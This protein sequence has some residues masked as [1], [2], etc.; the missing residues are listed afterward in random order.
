[1]MGFGN[2]YGLYAL[3]ALVPFII[4]YL[5]RPKPLERV[6]PSLM[7]L[8]KE[9]RHARQYSFLRKLL[10]NLLFL[11]QLLAIACI[12]FA[13]AIPYIDIP[14]S[15]ISD[16]TVVIIDISASMQTKDGAKT[17]FDNAI[18][19]VKKDLS[20]R[21]GIILAENNPLIILEN[22]R[23]DEASA[24]IDKLKPK[25][26]GTNLGD[27]M[28]LARSVLNGKGRVIVASDFISTEG[29]DVMT[30]K[31]TLEAGGN[32]VKFINVGNKADNIGIINLEVDKKETKA[33]IKNFKEK[34]ENVK[35]RLKKD[36]KML[37]EKTIE[38][39]PNSIESIVFSTP[40]EQ[41]RIELDVKDSLDAD[42]T[43]FISAPDKMKMSVLMITNQKSNNY[44]KSA[45]E[46]SGD[47][48]LEIREPP[49]TNAESISHDVV[50]VNKITKDKLLPHEFNYLEE[51]V[52]KGG[53]LIISAQDDLDKID[54]SDLL[55]AKLGKKGENSRVCVNL[56]I[57]FTKM[58]DKNSCFTTSRYFETKSDNRSVAIASAGEN[59]ILSIKE[60]GSGKVFYYGIF[61]ET[62]DFKTSI[63]YPL[64]WDALMG[65]LV[66]TEDIDDYNFKT[67]SI[68]VAEEQKIKVPSGN[69]VTA[70]KLLLED[71]GF[72]EM[73][74]KKIAANLIDEKESDV[75]SNSGELT[76]FSESDSGF[77][78]ENV[79]VDLEMPLL[80]AAFL[81]LC[82]EI[83]YIKMRGDL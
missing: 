28:L 77:V 29:P 79:K 37:D 73:S 38:I 50:V 7:F 71:A 8:I 14:S 34:K 66:Q 45:L 21:N 70:S 9:E 2:I 43:A 75:A 74:K 44:I 11:L 40:A 3:L 65:F 80:I 64:F 36:D 39:L 16:K 18:E 1:M 81:I 25:A 78:K 46:A 13:I 35:I 22:G 15:I 4:L 19:M 30:V 67:G 20:S 24:I 56:F 54:T 58:F 41:S 60:H 6:I 52:K 32:M 63:N 62:S 42:N 55:P 53:N 61:D 47:I 68:V 26:T 31:R 59:Q 48:E 5:R 69:Y 57:Q 27:A 17:R 72:Y 49:A 82:L 12:G 51:Y 76:A 23:K 10:H 83:V 33:F